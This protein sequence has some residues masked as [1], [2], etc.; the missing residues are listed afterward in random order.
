MC[1]FSLKAD[2]NKFVGCEKDSNK[3]VEKSIKYSPFCIFPISAT[4]SLGNVETTLNKLAARMR[5][6]LQGPDEQDP[7]QSE[8]LKLYEQNEPK[9]VRRKEKLKQRNQRRIQVGLTE[10]VE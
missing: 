2:Q 8:D 4:N 9:R 10:K 5:K 1:A 7:E 6:I 3:K